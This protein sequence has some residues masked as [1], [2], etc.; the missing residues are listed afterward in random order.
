[1]RHSNRILRH[2]L[3]GSYLRPPAE[4]GLDGRWYGLPTHGQW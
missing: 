4:K 1:M 2:S 3:D